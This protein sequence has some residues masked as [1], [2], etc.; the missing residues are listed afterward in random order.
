MSPSKNPA[1]ASDQPVTTYDAYIQGDAIEEEN[2][3][4]GTDD[5]DK[6]LPLQDDNTGTLVYVLYGMVVDKHTADDCWEVGVEW[7]EGFCKERPC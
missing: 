7:A 2:K 6:K 3:Q 1:P 5:N 4:T